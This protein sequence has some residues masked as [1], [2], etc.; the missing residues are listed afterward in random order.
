MRFQ[1]YIEITYEFGVNVRDLEMLKHL[2]RK[3]VVWEG[4]DTKAVIAHFPSK[5]KFTLG[6]PPPVIKVITHTWLDGESDAESCVGSALRIGERHFSLDPA[7]NRRIV[8]QRT[9]L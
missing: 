2:A 7:T 6:A 8:V 4:S 9:V 1:V 5:V 3:G